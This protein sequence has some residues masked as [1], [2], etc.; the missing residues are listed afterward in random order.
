MAAQWWNRRLRKEH[1]SLKNYCPA[2]INAEPISENN[3]SHWQAVILGP[4]GSDYEG[5]TYY[6]ELK[7]PKGYPMEPPSVRFLT[8]ILHPN[9]DKESGGLCLMKDWNPSLSISKVLLMI[10]ALLSD[11]QPHD[12][13]DVELAKLYLVN[14]KGY[15]DMVRKHVH[16]HAICNKHQYSLKKDHRPP[17]LGQ[18]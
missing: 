11:P 9:V 14:R 18:I 16:Q 12:P 8:P 13:M 10:Q 2:G 6:L 3:L 4:S 5:G 17:G 1:D 15:Q 7:F